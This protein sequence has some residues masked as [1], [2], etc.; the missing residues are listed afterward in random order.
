MKEIPKREIALLHIS[1]SA[2]SI[3]E[4][5]YDALNLSHLFL[6]SVYSNSIGQTGPTVCP[7]QHSKFIDHVV[8]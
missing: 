2:A 5:D 7:C 1:A 6:L 3:K 4:E 8:I